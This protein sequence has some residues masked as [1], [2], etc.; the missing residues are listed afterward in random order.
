[1]ADVDPIA[2]YARAVTRAQDLGVD[3]TPVA[4]ATA[5]RSGRP[6]VRIVLIRHVD[7]RGFVFH[8]NYNSRKAS[9][10]FEN[11]RAALC[12]HWPTV[13]EQIRVEGPVSRISKE[14]SD[15]YFAGRP[16]GSQIG[17]W[18]SEQSAE[19]PSAD[20]LDARTR[21]IEE[22]FA[23]QPV[24]RPPHWGGLRVTPERMEFWY[25]RTSRL[26]E[27]FLYIRSGDAWQMSRLY[28]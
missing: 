18:A 26:H 12:F 4:L 6:S 27:R 2:R 11:P 23:G 13:E 19:L 24:P 20:A 25:G 3:T 14:E 22:R 10:I 8:T 15:E 28:P 5:D 9:E 1:M 7:E 17:A 16:R 21:A